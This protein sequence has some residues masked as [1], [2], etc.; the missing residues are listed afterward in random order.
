MGNG[1]SERRRWEGRGEAGASL[2]CSM[3]EIYQEPKLGVSLA[4]R[5]LEMTPRGRDSVFLDAQP[6]WSPV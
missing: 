6:P 4:P 1:R 2:C 3:N 5:E